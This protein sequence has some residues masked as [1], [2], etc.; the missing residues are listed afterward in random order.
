MST[1][2][3]VDV[4]AGRRA[5]AH[6]WRTAAVALV[7]LAGVLAATMPAAAARPR[8]CRAMPHTL[9]TS[10]QAR[11]WRVGRSL[12]ACIALDTAPRTHRMGPWAPGT[13]IFLEGLQ[14]AWTTPDVDL[15]GR[16]DR[17]WAADIATGERSMTDLP[18]VPASGAASARDARLETLLGIDGAVLAWSTRSGDVVIAQNDPQGE[19]VAAGP[20][21]GPLV[22]DRRRL[23]VARYPGRD[24]LLLGA[25]LHLF[26]EDGDGDECETVSDYALTFLDAANRATGVVWSGGARN[27][28]CQER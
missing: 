10:A 3:G 27:P 14:L 1:R 4:P 18:L 8:P 20:L 11:V 28:D 13:R 6:A 21:P 9:A 2:A 12:W 23:L 26:A 16:S 24:P 19:P 22:P 15:S 7:V 17:I 5:P 25:S